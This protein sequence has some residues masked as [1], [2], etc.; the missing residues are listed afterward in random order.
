[1]SKNILFFLPIVA[2]AAFF[3]QTRGTT[4][5]RKRKAVDWIAEQLPDMYTPADVIVDSVAHRAVRITACSFGSAWFTGCYVMPSRNK[6][7]RPATIP[8]GSRLNL[9]DFKTFLR[10]EM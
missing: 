5:D 3:A 8:A 1:M 7:P 2:V 6:A 4:A 9:A 10:H